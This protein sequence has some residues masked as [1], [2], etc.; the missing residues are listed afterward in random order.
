MEAYY[1]ILLVAGRFAIAT[2]LL[3]ALYWLIW[4]KQATYRA[5]RMYLL[6]LPIVA[7]LI[8]LVRM[9][10]YKPDPVVIT[11]KQTK[12]VSLPSPKEET[13]HRTIETLPMERV[14][15]PTSELQTEQPQNAWFSQTNVL[16]LA[17]TFI[18]ILL[19]VPFTVSLVQLHLLLKN[20]NIERDEEN[21]IYILTGTA[22]KAPFSFYRNI[23]LPQYLT[24]TQRRMILAH[25]R[26]HILHRHY[27]DVWVIEIVT[28]LLWWNPFLWWT[29]S[30]LRN[31]HEFEADSDVLAMG[32]NVSAYQAILIE[33]VLNGDIV[34]TN[35]FNH[36]F[37]RRR[38]IEMLQTTNQHMSMWRK[39]GTGTWIALVVALMCCT[40]GE[41]ET[42]Y[43][44][45]VSQ[46]TVST[47][48]KVS[49]T[50]KTTAETQLEESSL[51]A[52]L[53]VMLDDTL[54][55]V[56]VDS[57]S[58]TSDAIGYALPFNQSLK[59]IIPLLGKEQADALG[60]LLNA[61]G[62]LQ[63]I[64][65]EQYEAWQ[66]ESADTLPSLDF[67]NQNIAHIQKQVN[68]QFSQSIGRLIGDLIRTQTNSLINSSLLDS[69]DAKEIPIL[70]SHISYSPGSIEQ[71]INQ[72][73]LDWLMGGQGL[74]EEDYNRLKSTSSYPDNLPTMEQFNKG[75]RERSRKRVNLLLKQIYQA[76]ESVGKQLE[77]YVALYGM[78]PE[79]EVI[80]MPITF[81]DGK[82]MIY[83][84]N[85][86]GISRYEANETN[87]F[88]SPFYEKAIKAKEN[89]FVIEGFVD[90]NIT[91]SCY[92]IYL[93][94]E[95]FKIQ[96]EPADT[97]P[98]VNKRF[99]YVLKTNKMTA[100]RLRCIFPGGKICEASINLFF[101][102]GETV[103][104][105]V[106]NGHYNL[107]KSPSYAEKI[108]KA[109]SVIRE[110]TRWE[111][112]HLPKIKGK[113]WKEISEDF[114]PL[115]D[116]REVYFNDKETVLRIACRQYTENMN[117]SKDAYLVDNKG[118]KYC[119]KHALMGNVDSNND[120]EVRIFGGY[121]AFE[122]V[123]DD[124]RSLTFK[125]RGTTIKRIKEAKKGKIIY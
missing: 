72:F 57:G 50:I 55:V 87:R 6:T 99:T 48:P 93:A 5:K 34:I 67:I 53:D 38:F 29:R 77:G 66:K 40:V 10:V 122:P 36:S 103:R 78:F 4:R 110:E 107:D 35:G 79:K 83:K 47:S 120:Q 92:L 98:V 108:N 64:S 18:I 74:S 2:G 119:L 84:K 62:S 85:G 61:L 37:I 9:E 76:D 106:H 95:H 109:M 63:E 117:I 22:V 70:T 56:P 112:P 91:D 41:A 42:I 11:V 59:D 116:V 24:E 125:D 105:Y 25:E 60:S 90:E 96:D 52:H 80:E 8:A 14:V 124:V 89:E 73:M 33:E 123:P 15:R 28:R 31:V 20:L 75:I 39:A 17:Y 12:Q 54:V 46:P 30:E 13:S 65:P 121:F 7:L 43:R 16:A 71:I 82:V 51:L 69:I 86:R 104:L 21:N 100:G 97:V 19:F 88:T 32:E 94:D 101:V 58:Q 115:L 114:D 111:S 1:P 44:T 118:N 26:S 27:I 45:T 49:S 3:M 68:D 23:Y 102:P 81:K 113:V